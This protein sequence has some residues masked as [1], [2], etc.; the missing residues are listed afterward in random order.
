MRIEQRVE[1]GETLRRRR[2]RRA[3]GA[4]DV[5]DLLRAEKLDRSEPSDRLLGRDGEARAPQQRR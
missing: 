1:F 4:A 3:R 2:Q 5:A